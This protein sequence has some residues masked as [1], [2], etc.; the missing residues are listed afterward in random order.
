MWRR[1]LD[2]GY[3]LRNHHVIRVIPFALFFLAGCGP[4][5]APNQLP[6]T[7]QVIIV[8][9]TATPNA[10][11][12][13]IFVPVDGVG[14][15]ERVLDE[16]GQTLFQL[17]SGQR[18]ADGS[19]LVS[20]QSDGL[21]T[22]ITTHMARTGA[23]SSAITQTGRMTLTA[24]SPDG[25]WAVMQTAPGQFRAVDTHRAISRA[26]TLEG[27][28]ALL[29][30]SNDGRW[31]YARA[32]P[33][34]N[35]N[36]VFRFALDGEFASQRVRFK[37][38][39]APD[40]GE[41]IQRAFVPSGHAL[42]ALMRDR[43]S[44]QAYAQVLDLDTGEGLNLFLP[45]V[46]DGDTDGAYRLVMGVSGRAYA[47]NLADGVVAELDLERHQVTQFTRFTPPPAHNPNANFI[48]AADGESVYFGSGRQIW[49]YDIARN[50]VGK[51]MTLA[52]NIIG[53]AAPGDGRALL[54]LADGSGQVVFGY[55][56][57]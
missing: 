9:V 31:L 47:I 12:D 14:Q 57:R 27:N 34:P 53:I 25:N 36:M 49:A 33:S 17:P 23:V 55:M 8:Q 35:E 50:A 29:A 6:P 2:V 32:A 28:F 21:N 16:Q 20:A 46:G 56:L 22:R 45:L 52:Q 39:D 51:P 11:T 37:A 4:R 42:V 40:T 7:P 3:W 38:E 15:G 26:I 54:A 43:A 44:G 24:I 48:E 10:P 30:M 41:E 18:T 13:L 19:Q 5:R 1:S